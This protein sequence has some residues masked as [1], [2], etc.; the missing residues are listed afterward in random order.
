MSLLD[1][2]RHR[3]Y[4]LVRGERY[5]LEVARELRFH[6]ELDTLARTND[7]AT[8]A[9]A[10][11][12]ARQMLGNT[13]YYREEVRRMTL[14]H[15]PDRLRQDAGYALRGLRR[16]PGF[17]IAVVLTIGLGIGVNAALFSLLDRIFFQAPAGVVRPNEVRRV[18][19]NFVNGRG[20]VGRL[21]T[22]RWR[23]RSFERSA[24]RSTPR[25]RWAS[26]A[27]LIRQRCAMG[28]RAFRFGAVG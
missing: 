10:E 24:P 12:A 4:A 22:R 13:T 18:Y 15:W 28:P 21:T 20:S 7:G 23:I 19:L 26:S 14:L 8:A 6:T 16:T 5:A 9:N 25:W 27:A 3:L 2:L 1:G 11:L 17:T